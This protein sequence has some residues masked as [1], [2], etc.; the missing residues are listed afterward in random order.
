MTLLKAKH[1]NIQGRRKSL[2][3]TTYLLLNDYDQGAKIT[4][5]R[6]DSL[7]I[8]QLRPSPD[9]VST[10]SSPHQCLTTG[11]DRFAA[12]PCASLGDA[13]YSSSR[14]PWTLK[15]MV[16]SCLQLALAAVQKTSVRMEAPVSPV[17]VPTAVTAGL[18]SKADTVS[19]VSQSWLLRGYWPWGSGGDSLGLGPGMLSIQDAFPQV[20]FQSVR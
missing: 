9:P 20:G 1:V 2:E 12:A 19:L 5:Q 3:I 15:L 18:G 6:M 16:L 13:A 10:V 8:K 17:P 7:L 4:P 11:K 14:P